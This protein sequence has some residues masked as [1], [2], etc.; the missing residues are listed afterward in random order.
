MM[1]T[2]YT[3]APE[4]IEW[5]NHNLVPIEAGVFRH[6]RGIINLVRLVDAAEEGEMPKYAALAAIRNYNATHRTDV[7]YEEIRSRSTTFI[8]ADIGEWAAYVDDAAATNRVVS[9]SYD[10]P[11]EALENADPDISW[12][13]LWL[14][15]KNEI[16]VLRS[17]YIEHGAYVLPPEVVASVGSISNG[18]VREWS[19][20]G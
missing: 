4:I 3:P 5:M 20:N 17:P 14:P 15:N 16:I 18:D 2:T 13:V 1:Y 12:T 11:L 6:Y 10:D 7:T 8:L 9:G 19:L